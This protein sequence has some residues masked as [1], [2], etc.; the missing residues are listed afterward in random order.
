MMPL[1]F[2]LAQDLVKTATKLIE[3]KKFK[4]AL[5]DMKSQVSID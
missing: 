5:Y 2:V 3:Q 4:H 1:S